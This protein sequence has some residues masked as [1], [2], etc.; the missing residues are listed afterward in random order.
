M[1]TQLGR[2]DPQGLG[3]I[4][5]TSV[6]KYEKT[7]DDIRTI[8]KELNVNFVLEG[9]VRE[10]S[11]QAFITAQLVHVRDQTELWSETY[12]R[13]FSGIFAI[14]RDLARR[15]AESLALKLLPDRENALAR[16][17]TVSTEAYDAYLKGRYAWNQ[18]TL[19]GFRQALGAFE[20]AVHLDPNYAMAYD[21]LARTNLSLVDYRFVAPG[22]GNERAGQAVEKAIALDGSIPESYVLHAAVL[23]RSDPKQPGIEDAYRR[24]LNLNPSDAEAHEQYGL[25]LRDSGRFADALRQMHRALILNPVSPRE[26]MLAGWVMLDAGHDAEAAGE[27]Q[28][29]LDIEPNYPPGLYFMAIVKE[30]H[31]QW[32]EAVG[33]LERSVASSGRTPKYLHALGV[34]YAKTGRQEQAKKILDE[35]RDQAKRGY[36]EPGFITSL[37]TQLESRAPGNPP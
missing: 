28:K 10:D 13:P 27:F 7:D 31:N 6:M 3:V 9:S 16:A 17:E 19:D 20:D 23:S 4:A 12:E 34:A 30:R 5:R 32:E 35:L 15:V 24:A 37:E 33:L 2:M 1:I 29:A 21:G 8:G 25:F 18:G 11:T 22:D 36:V 26:R 14:Q